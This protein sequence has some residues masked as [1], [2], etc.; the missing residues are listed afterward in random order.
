MVLE[1][2]RAF[3]CVRIEIDKGLSGETSEAPPPFV[4]VGHLI[5]QSLEDFQKG[6]AAHGQEFLNDIPNYTTITPQFQVSDI[7]A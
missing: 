1:K 3:G 2:L 6:M 7:V 5:C 4:A